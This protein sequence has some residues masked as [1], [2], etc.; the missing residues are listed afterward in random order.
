MP[1]PALDFDAMASKFKGKWGAAPSSPPVTDGPITFEQMSKAYQDQ[2]SSK[3]IADNIKHE[4]PMEVSPT[5]RLAIEHTNTLHAAAHG[6]SPVI[7][8]PDIQGRGREMARYRPRQA[9][10][11]DRSGRR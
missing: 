6:V 8:H 1:D 2:P 3:Q 9:R 7:N 5:Q 10:H 4:S 11:T